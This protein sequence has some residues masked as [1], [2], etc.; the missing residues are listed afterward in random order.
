FV[1]RQYR[2][3]AAEDGVGVGTYLVPVG[4][5]PRQRF[6]QGVRGRR[7]AGF[8]TA[9]GEI[10]PALLEV[11]ARVQQQAEGLLSAGGRF[12]RRLGDL[13]REYPQL[14]GVTYVFGIV[15]TLHVHIDEVDEQQN[16]R[17]DQR[18][19]QATDVTVAA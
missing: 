2:V 10:A 1:Q 4:L 5:G 18:G 12:G 19:E 3:L 13:L 7:Q 16:Q 11:I 14:T 17:Q 8:L 6:L 15:G 9:I